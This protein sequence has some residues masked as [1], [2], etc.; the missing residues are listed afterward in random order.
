[1]IR[2]VPGLWAQFTAG[3]DGRGRLVREQAGLPALR[4][5][6]LP[7]VG[8]ENWSVLYQGQVLLNQSGTWRLKVE[9]DD[10]IRIRV[11]G[12]Q[13]VDEWREQHNRFE[14]S[15]EVAK[16]GWQNIGNSVFSRQRRPATESALAI[17]GI[18]EVA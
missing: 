3:R 11:N 7:G 14:N 1:M 6:N 2:P 15:F 13:V 4:D 8:R 16:E 12:K 10:G 9:S 18:E 5:Y 17:T